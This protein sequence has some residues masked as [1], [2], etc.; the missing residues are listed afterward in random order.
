MSR[1]VECALR[2][3]GRPRLRRGCQPPEHDAPS[4]TESLHNA[5]LPEGLFRQT[6]EAPAQ[7]R[8][9]PNDT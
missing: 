4:D 5:R 8:T 3:A 6:S 9:H 7:G 2:E 1:W